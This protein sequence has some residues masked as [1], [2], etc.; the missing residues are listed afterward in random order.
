MPFVLN[1]LSVN[2]RLELATTL[3]FDLFERAVP[4]LLI[5]P[6]FRLFLTFPVIYIECQVMV[7]KLVHKIG[8]STH[9]DN[10]AYRNA[11]TD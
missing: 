11:I 9:G 5:S 6:D 1:T 8:S 3:E 4:S 7:H 2:M 10:E